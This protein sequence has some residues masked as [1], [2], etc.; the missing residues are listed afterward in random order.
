M[1]LFYKLAFE[2]QM[3]TPPEATRLN[4]LIELL[5]LLPLRA[6]SKSTFQYETPCINAHWEIVQKIKT[7]QIIRIS[8]F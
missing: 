1:F 6:N 3:S 7:V 4:N 8:H 2:T 5:V